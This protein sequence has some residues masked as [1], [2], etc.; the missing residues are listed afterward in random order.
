LKHEDSKMKHENNQIRV[1]ILGEYFPPN[2]NTAAS[3]L[4]SFFH[5]L[6]EYGITPVVFCRKES[7]KFKSPIQQ[8]GN[9]E[10]HYVQVTPDFYERNIPRLKN[11]ILKNI[12]VAISLVFEN[13]RFKRKHDQYKTAITNYLLNHSVDLILASGTPFLMFSVASEIN[14]EFKIPWIADYRDDWSTN[15]VF[16]TNRLALW[17]R[18]FDSRREKKFTKNASCFTTVSNILRQ[19]IEKSIGKKGYLVENGF[20]EYPEIQIVSGKPLSILYAG[21]IYNSQDLNFLNQTIQLLKAQNIRQV[22]FIFLGSQPDLLV[23]MDQ[24]YV[25]ILPRVTREKAWA[26]I[27]NADILLY[28]SFKS[29]NEILKGVPASKLYDYISSRKPILVQESDQD[30][31]E[32]KLSQSGQGLFCESPEKMFEYILSYKRQKETQGYITPID[33]PATFLAQ[34]S[35]KYQAYLLSEVIKKH[36]Q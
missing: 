10:V 9:S 28:I 32:E 16:N 22:E 2:P 36:L 3:R 33:I 31:V 13:S 8:T 6:P 7:I 29:G 20:W 5:F 19:R 21:S 27:S 35:R 4:H 18:W 34:N 30:I 26:F 11:K 1:L 24:T 15:R 23:Y 14:Q 25:K 17:L 12:L